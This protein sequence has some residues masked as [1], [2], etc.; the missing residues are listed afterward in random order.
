[1]RKQQSS[2]NFS[3][4][5]LINNTMPDAQLLLLKLHSNCRMP[6]G[7][8]LSERLMRASG[9][10]GLFKQL[11]NIE[12]PL[13]FLR[14][15]FLCLSSSIT[16]L[17]RCFLFV[18]FWWRLV[19]SECKWGRGGRLR[20]RWVAPHCTILY[21]T[22]GNMCEWTCAFLSAVF[23]FP[24]I[25]NEENLIGVSKPLPKQLWQAKKVRSL[26]SFYITD[27]RLASSLHVWLHSFYADKNKLENGTNS[28]CLWQRRWSWHRGF[29]P[30]LRRDCRSN[31]SF[32]SDR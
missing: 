21:L 28:I 13:T 8:L 29:L 12:Y 30:W 5:S 2:P 9:V 26:L 24:T 14:L 27:H 6:E 19:C 11:V 22:L 15:C 10:L 3:S 25:P 31:Q 23:S 4:P 17:A 18:C 20:R 16:P 32:L 1:M 7:L